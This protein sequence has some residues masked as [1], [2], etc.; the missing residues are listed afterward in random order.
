MGGVHVSFVRVA[1]VIL[2]FKPDIDRLP[3]LREGAPEVSPGGVVPVPAVVA[4]CVLHVGD[5]SKREELC[6][7]GEVRPAMHVTAASAMIAVGA[8]SVG[9]R[10][11][12]TGSRDVR[13]YSTRLL[14]QGGSQVSTSHDDPAGSSNRQLD[15]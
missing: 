4:V 1:P 9:Y 10:G 2:L 3:E 8:A 14:R 7:G 15:I 5:R 12:H 6:A 11:I 13:G